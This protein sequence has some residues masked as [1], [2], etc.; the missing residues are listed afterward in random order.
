MGFIRREPG[1]PGV[2]RSN[3]EVEE[4]LGWMEHYVRDNMTV[5]LKGERERDFLSISS[6]VV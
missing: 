2:S 4:Q 3:L 5:D 1:A 6:E